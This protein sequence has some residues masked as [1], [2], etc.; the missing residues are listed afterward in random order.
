MTEARRRAYLEAMGIDVWLARPDPED[1]LRLH[2]PADSNG[3]G[4][5]LLICER[6]DLPGSRL[7]EDLCRALGGRVNWSWPA[8]DM[9]PGSST[10]NELIDER[11]FT[12][13][14]LLGRDLPSALGCRAESHV[15]GSARVWPAPSLDELAESPQARKALW[16]QV[17]ARRAV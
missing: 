6:P 3:Q 8:G 9:E 12:E 2:C 16:T 10:L 4:G 1:A 7:A 15:Q 13:V 14:F 5:I 11:L 17:L